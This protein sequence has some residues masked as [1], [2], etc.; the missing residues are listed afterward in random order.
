V[1]SAAVAARQPAKMGSGPLDMVDYLTGHGVKISRLAENRF[2]L[3]GET[4]LFGAVLKRVN[5]RRKAADLDPLAASQV[6]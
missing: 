6:R 1:P 5:D 4:V 3:E 2:M